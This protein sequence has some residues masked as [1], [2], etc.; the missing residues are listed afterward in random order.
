MFNIFI[1]SGSKM[2]KTLQSCPD[3]TCFQL[4]PTLWL[5]DNA[6]R[7]TNSGRKTNKYH[8]SSKDHDAL[9]R[10][11]PVHQPPQQP[12]CQRIQ[13]TATANT[14]TSSTDEQNDPLAPPY[15]ASLGASLEDQWS[16]LYTER[17]QPTPQ[18]GRENYGHFHFH[19]LGVCISLVESDAA[20]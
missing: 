6:H 5:G 13:V 4:P 20:F 9:P 14:P 2:L 16:D 19:I 11:T 1:P 7:L 8:S 18:D 12:T 17:Q 10:P 15:P 3:T